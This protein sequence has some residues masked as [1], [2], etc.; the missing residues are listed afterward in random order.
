MVRGRRYNKDG[1]GLCFSRRMSSHFGGLLMIQISI[2]IEN[3]ADNDDFFIK[4]HF[5]LSLLSGCLKRCRGRK[6]CYKWIRA[7]WN[8]FDGVFGC[9]GGFSACDDFFGHDF[10]AANR[11]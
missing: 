8:E 9:C 11:R 10:L 5:S 3:G 7:F 2:L 6:C 1:F 4:A